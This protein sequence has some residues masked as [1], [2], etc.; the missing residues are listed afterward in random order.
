LSH[1]STDFRVSKK[2][3]HMPH[4]NLRELVGVRPLKRFIKGQVDEMVEI[5]ERRT[6]ESISQPVSPLR[7]VVRTNSGPTAR[8][9]IT[10]AGD[11]KAHSSAHH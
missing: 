4:T 5:L 8:G 11:A 7:T 9:S 1:R 10:H 2:L 6:Q 3:L